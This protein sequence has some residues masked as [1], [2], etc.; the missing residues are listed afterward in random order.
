MDVFSAINDILDRRF[1]VFEPECN[2]CR[3]CL[4]IQH[5]YRIVC[6]K[7]L[8]PFSTFVIWGGCPDY[9]SEKGEIKCFP[10]YR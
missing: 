6:V 5:Q 7:H 4:F 3:N 8:E 10:Y 2:G 9:E 1:S